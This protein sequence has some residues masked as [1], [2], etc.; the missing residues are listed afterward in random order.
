MK[1]TEVGRVAVDGAALAIVD[2]L[3]VSENVGEFHIRNTS[4]DGWY[5]VFE[6]TYK[7]EQYLAVRLTPSPPGEVP[8]IQSDVE[9]WRERMTGDGKP[10]GVI[11]G[12]RP[13]TNK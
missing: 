7:G 8:P 6:F 2:P 13:R 3:F 1:L 11:V 12:L 9:D 5:P 4:S 10:K